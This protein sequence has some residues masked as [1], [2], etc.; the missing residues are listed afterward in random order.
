MNSSSKRAIAY[1]LSLVMLIPSLPSYVFASGDA[2]VT[3]PPQAVQE[4]AA[5]SGAPQESLTQE[6]QAQEAA[7]TGQSGEGQQAPSEDSTEVE[8]QGQGQQAPPSGGNPSGLGNLVLQGEAAGPTETPDANGGVTQPG[9]GGQTPQAPSGNESNG[10]TENTEPNPDG[11]EGP[12]AATEGAVGAT[13]GAVTT[14]AAVGATTDGAINVT[15]GAVTEGALELTGPAV[16]EAQQIYEVR[17]KGNDG[18]DV[19]LPQYVSEGGFASNPGPAAVPR[20]NPY[21]WVS[22]LGW[23]TYGSSVDAP[24][25]FNTPVTGDLELWAYFT[26]DFLVSYLDGYGHVFKTKRIAPDALIPDLTFQEMLDFAAPAGEYF[27]YWT[28]IDENGNDTGVVFTGNTLR[29][30]RDITLK[31]VTD[32]GRHN[33]FFVSDGT[34]VD[35]QVVRHGDKA[36]VPT[37]PPSRIGYNFDHWSITRGGVTAFDFNTPI[38]ADIVFYAVWVPIP[39]TYKVIFHNEKP[40]IPGTPGPNDFEFNRQFTLGTYIDNNG[41][42]QTALAGMNVADINVKKFVEQQ[43]S[44]WPRYSSYYS[45]YNTDGYTSNSTTL[46]GNGATVINVYFKRNVYDMYFYLKAWDYYMGSSQNT[47]YRDIK[48]SMQFR[49]P[50][51]PLYVTSN[52]LNEMY[53]LSAK[54]EQDIEDMWPSADNA[55][56]LLTDKG[57][58]PS[59]LAYIFS[60]WVWVI[61]ETGLYEDNIVWS[62]KRPTM[63]DEIIEKILRFPN[64]KI[65]M[66]WDITERWYKYDYHYMFEILSDEPQSGNGMVQGDTARYRQSDAYTQ[67]NITNAMQNVYLKVID[68]MR[69]S[70]DDINI[71]PRANTREALYLA[72]PSAEYQTMNRAGLLANNEV[73]YP[74]YL[75][76]KRIPYRLTFD[77]RSSAAQWPSYPHDYSVMVKYGEL[78][79]SGVPSVYPTLTENGVT[80]AFDGW[81]RDVDMNVPYAPDS[82]RMPNADTVLYAKWSGTK[83]TVSFYDDL[84]TNDLVATKTVEIGG[85]LTPADTPYQ[86]GQSY[87]KGKF[88]GWQIFVGADMPAWFSYETPVNKNISLHAVWDSSPRRVYYHNTTPPGIVGDP[89]V[90]DAYYLDGTLARVKGSNGMRRPG[91]SYDMFFGWQKEERGVIGGRIYYRD[92]E[93]AIQGSDIDLY[94]VFGPP[95]DAALLRLHRND[96][97]TPEFVYDRWVNVSQ[98]YIFEDEYVINGPRPNYVF[99]G[100][101]LSPD[102]SGV[103]YKEGDIYNAARGETTDFYARWIP[104]NKVSFDLRDLNDGGVYGTTADQTEFFVESGNTLIQAGVREPRVTPDAY[105]RFVRWAA[106]YDVSRGF[107][108]GYVPQGDVTYRAVYE[109]L[110]VLPPE[111]FNVIPYEGVY[112]NAHHSVQVVKDPSLAA[113]QPLFSTDGGVTWGAANPMYKNVK[114]NEETYPVLVRLTVPGYQPTTITSGVRILRR[115]I[116]ITAPSANIRVGSGLPTDPSWALT[117]AGFALGE[118]VG[119]L[120]QLPPQDAYS[121]F[122]LNPAFVVGQVGSF[123]TIVQSGVFASNNYRITTVDGLLTVSQAESVTNISKQV[124]DAAKGQYVDRLHV[125]D[126]DSILTYKIKVEMPAVTEGYSSL[127]IQ[128]ILPSALAPAPVGG[129]VAVLVD[130]QPFANGQAQIKYPTYQGGVI[131]YTVDPAYIHSLAGK[132]VEMI[133]QTVLADKAFAGKITN[134]GRVLVNSTATPDT[135]V[136][137]PSGS[138]EGPE[139]IVTNNADEITKTVWDPAQ[140]KFVNSLTVTDRNQVLTYQ[141]AVKMPANVASITSIEILDILPGELS[142]VPPSGN[143]RVA[144]SGG[145]VTLSGALATKTVDGKTALSYL[146]TDASVISR[147]AGRTVTLTADT[148]LRSDARGVINNLARVIIN[149]DSGEDGE[150]PAVTVA[151]PLGGVTKAVWDG[152]AWSARYETQDAAQEFVYRVRAT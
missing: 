44:N 143:A 30:D 112:D 74:L 122:Y 127:E 111:A 47:R 43:S 9:T 40:N 13:G 6:S 60:G 51:S 26:T 36:T 12:T 105:H 71:T 76:Y 25:D 45:D 92:N 54:Y 147:L 39:V 80:Y 149:E 75:F 27:A 16:S 73:A 38:T 11:N 66:M 134:V 145:G 140:G 84:T 130:G 128:D 56:I 141:V 46:L 144:V 108:P 55:D 28:I 19:K 4:G 62:S 63:T 61:E 67:S 152:A 118:D 137:G 148:R 119:A 100:W 8:G 86:V 116:T 77:L 132:T 15:G 129:N 98:P 72:S 101:T 57:P 58:N 41:V 139:V 78:I 7:P 65:W 24:Y 123:A 88:R 131:S 48:A 17:F 87:R 135:P 18:S 110:P 95:S 35:F 138:V 113:Y 52:N 121:R 91:L 29:A 50:G 69:A 124:W 115:P 89:P 136:T 109:L 49:A 3:A 31:S 150:P 37:P 21:G 81:Y 96:G 82:D 32:R 117:F 59:D 90:D 103:L 34:Q 142:L 64:R 104:M 126:K 2:D 5:P 125:T 151:D 1:I 93:I 146:I 99:A 23:Y 22:F 33:V 97:A 14:G 114:G 53:K 68:G 94:P 83:A 42:V 85:Y 70:A 79:R 102:G 10:G 133:V 107:E 20:P 106:S 120:T